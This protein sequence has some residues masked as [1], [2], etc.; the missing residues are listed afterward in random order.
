MSNKP[1]ERLAV[2][3]ILLSITE[4]SGA[5]NQHCLAMPDKRDITICTYFRPSMAVPKELTLLAGDNS[6]IGFLRTL[7]AALAEKKFDIIHA[8]SPHVGFL[9]VVFDLP[10]LRKFKRSTVYNVQNS[11]QNYKLRNKLLMIPVFAY[12]QRVVCCSQAC[13][14]SFPRFYKWLA[15]DRLCVIPNG[16]DVDR[17]DRIM[18]YSPRLHQNGTFIVASVGRLIEIKNPFAILS[19]FQQSDDQL[20]RLMFI[21]E[22]HLRDSLA[23]EIE[24]RGLCE[25]VELTGLIPRDKV[26]ENLSKADVVVSASRGEGLPVAVIEAMACR[27]PVIL[28]DIEPHRE[29]A[30]GADF[31]PLIHPDDVSGFARGI[32]R[33]R[34]MSA[35]ERAEIGEKC[36]RL[37]E[38]RYGLT[39]MHRGYQEVY[40]QVLGKH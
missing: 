19:A 30:A 39:A 13:L 23:T 6:L 4:T 38:E 14:E 37:A 1:K 16:L 32:E 31:I 22:G 15:G 20:S 26:F 7:K 25:R 27:C 24:A 40:T 5:Y 29:I 12:F 21:G 9:F 10:R 8:H 28:S 17:V 2:L 18:A 3:Q 11:Y 35:S 36:R 34:Q 33:F